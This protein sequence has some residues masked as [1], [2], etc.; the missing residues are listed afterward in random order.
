M[1]TPTGSVLT[2]NVVY[3]VRRAPSRSTAIDKRPVDGKVEVDE[4][5]LVPDTQC[6]KRI[7]GGVDKAVYASAPRTRPGGPTGSSARYH[8]ASW[9]R[10]SP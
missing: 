6:D 7:H 9:E 8:P 5:G 4:L 2:V 3:D 10:T 1:A